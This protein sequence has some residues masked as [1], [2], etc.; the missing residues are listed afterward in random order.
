M[1]V[2]D[3]FRLSG[4]VALVTGA[5]RGLGAVGACALA[6]A[7]GHVVL[8]GRDEGALTSTAS[9]ITHAGGTSSTVRLDVSD[10]ASVTVAFASAIEQHG[11]IDILVNNAGVQEQARVGEL[12]DSQWDWVIDVN[13]TGAF[14]CS[15][16]FVRHAHDSR[17]RSI[18]N[19]TSFA[20]VAGL[21]SLSAYCASKGGLE[22][23]T[24][25]LAVELAG[26]GIRV[27]ALAPGYALT[28][29]P[30]EVVQDAELN[31]RILRRIPLRRMAE[32]AEIGPP[33]VFLASAASSYMSGA[34]LHFDGGYSAQ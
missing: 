15:R 33:L 1:S 9:R 6:E 2:L 31:R 17:S 22:A 28:E 21:H 11:R 4:S 23:M 30:A 16:E 24:R 26:S 19:I 14:R 13:L 20:G 32:P 29:M 18:I 12:S 5:G 27:N 3:A 7:G 34:T 25:A 8:A 10:P